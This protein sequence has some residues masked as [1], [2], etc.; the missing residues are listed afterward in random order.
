VL[1][2]PDITA[3]CCL[4]PEPAWVLALAFGLKKSPYLIPSGLA[5]SQAVASFEYK[6]RCKSLQSKAVW[7]TSAVGTA[8]AYLSPARSAV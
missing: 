4:L 7:L 2:L 8:A 6:G 1:D 3:Q 5:G